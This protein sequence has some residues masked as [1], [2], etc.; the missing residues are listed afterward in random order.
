MLVPP[1]VSLSPMEMSHP[2]YLECLLQ[3]LV[4]V[5]GTSYLLEVGVF[6]FLGS[7]CCIGLSTLEVGWSSL[8]MVVLA[9]L[10]RDFI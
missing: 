5:W 8:E 3:I 6:G 9:G 1:V 7:D 4:I 2:S 10:L